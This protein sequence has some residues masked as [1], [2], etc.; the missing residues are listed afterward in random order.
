MKDKEIVFGGGHRVCPKC[1]ETTFG[2]VIHTCEKDIKVK[3]RVV[4]TQDV[5]DIDYRWNALGRL[6]EEHGTDEDRLALMLCRGDA[7][8]WRDRAAASK[9]I[10]ELLSMIDWI[11]VNNI[12]LCDR[13][14]TN[15]SSVTTSMGSLNPENNECTRPVCPSVL[16]KLLSDNIR[17]KIM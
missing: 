11:L 10:K 9:D 7:A 15:T 3:P 6:V 2:S 16:L 17:F 4:K 12:P 1:G 8:E 14:C 5:N 13:R